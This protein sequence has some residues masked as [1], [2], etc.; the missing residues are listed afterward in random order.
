M[1]DMRTTLDIEDELLLTVKQIAEQ[2]KT[3][4]AFPSFFANSR[5]NE[6]SRVQWPLSIE[7]YPLSM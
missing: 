2:R 6:T 7:I 1:M 5:R 3:A 4:A